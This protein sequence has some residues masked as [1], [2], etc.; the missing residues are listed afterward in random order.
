MR[1]SDFT[2]YT[3]VSRT[4]FLLATDAA[5]VKEGSNNGQLSSSTN[6]V[7]HRRAPTRNPTRRSL[8]PLRSCR[9]PRPTEETASRCAAPL[10]QSH[11]TP[12][13]CLRLSSCLS[14]RKALR[15]PLWT[16]NIGPLDWRFLA[17]AAH[18]KC[19]RIENLSAPA[20]C[21][22][23]NGWEDSARCTV[24]A[25]VISWLRRGTGQRDPK[26]LLLFLISLPGS[27]RC[28]RWILRIRMLYTVRGNRASLPWD[29]TSFPLLCL[30]SFERDPIY[31]PPA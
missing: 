31:A 26:V 14:S 17:W 6:R 29:S 9:N 15:S 5:A 11:P 22:F 19:M 3:G 24:G 12:R 30:F 27:P 10:S 1:L 4:R 16:G 18:R 2:E 20:P 13:L 7:R 25:R 28:I 8:P 23:S 21:G